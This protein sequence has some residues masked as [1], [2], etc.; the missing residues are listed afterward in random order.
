MKKLRPGELKSL[1]LGTQIWIWF[2]LVGLS[3]PDFSHGP[4]ALLVQ[5]EGDLGGADRVVLEAARVA[6]VAGRKKLGLHKATACNKYSGTSLPAS[7]PI[8][9]SLTPPMAYIWEQTLSPRRKREAGP[10]R[11]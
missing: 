3:E 8:G 11:T 1:G 10:P 7:L 2:G 5:K 6:V 4:A 9:C